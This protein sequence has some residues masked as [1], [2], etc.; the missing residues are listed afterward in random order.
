MN[1]LP[2]INGQKKALFTH[3]LKIKSVHSSEMLANLH[4]TARRHTPHDGT[5]CV[6]TNSK[7]KYALSY[8]LR[9]YFETRHSLC[10]YKLDCS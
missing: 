8:T 2:I 10:T 3:T 5:I 7:P 6:V 4:H 9:V 1:M